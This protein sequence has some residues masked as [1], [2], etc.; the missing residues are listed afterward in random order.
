MNE[1]SRPVIDFIKNI[2][3]SNYSKISGW[4]DGDHCYWSIGDVTIGDTTFGNIVLRYTIST[5]VWTVY[6]YPTQF[7]VSSKYNDGTDLFQ[8]VGDESGNVFK[9]NI[10]VTDNSTPIAYSLVHN[11]YD[12]DG[13]QATRKTI[14]KMLFAHVGGSG[15]KVS[16]QVEDDVE[17]DWSS[18][19]GEFGQRDTFFTN[20]SVRGRKCRFKI[21]GQSYGVPFI[22]YGP[23]ILEGNSELAIS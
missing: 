5:K 17:N 11:W 23:E 10:G 16:Y 2:S 12:V 18:G 6:S 19:L 21:L 13:S 15:T 4:E 22:Y 20:I 14:T 8:L 1:I 9:V 3:L 7:L